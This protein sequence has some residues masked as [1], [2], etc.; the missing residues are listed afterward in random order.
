[1]RYFSS[2]FLC[3]KTV[4]LLIALPLS[5][6]SCIKA[7]ESRGYTLEETNTSQLQQQIHTKSDALS[8]L[9]SPSSKSY[10]GKDTWYYISSKAEKVAFLNSKTIEQ[11]IISIEFNETGKVADFKQYTLQDAQQIQFARESTPTEGSDLSAVG[12]IFGNVGKFNPAGGNTAG[13]TSPHSQN[14]P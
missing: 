6:S 13:R 2:F 11:H 4:L 14:L 5:L 9:G 7:V 8:I 10:F 1:M 12:Q 3:I